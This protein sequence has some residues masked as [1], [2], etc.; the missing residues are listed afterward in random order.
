MLQSHG[1]CDVVQSTEMSVAF[2]V[3]LLRMAQASCLEEQSPPPSSPPSSPTD[4]KWQKGRDAW[5]VSLSES[6]ERFTS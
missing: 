4:K 2:S 6:Y 1:W 5:K 3:A